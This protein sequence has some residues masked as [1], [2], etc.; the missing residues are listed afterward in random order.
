M[1]MKLNKNALNAALIAMAHNSEESEIN[2]LEIGISIY[3]KFI[4]KEHA[5]PGICQYCGHYINNLS[6][7]R[8]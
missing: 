8:C 6:E 7:H 3:L 5:F 2:K 4:S 1:R